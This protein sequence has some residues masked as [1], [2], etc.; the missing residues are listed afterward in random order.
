M[1]ISNVP[2]HNTNPLDHLKLS[3]K[4]LIVDT[5]KAISDLLPKSGGK[6][7]WVDSAH[8]WIVAFSLAVTERDENK[9]VSFPSLYRELMNIQADYDAWVAFYNHMKQ[10]RFQSVRRTAEAISESQKLGKEGFLAPMN[11]IS[12]VFSWM[13]EP[14]IANSLHGGPSLGEINNPDRNVKWKIIIPAQYI[15]ICK[16]LVRS[17]IGRPMQDKMK[18]GGPQKV[19]VNIDEC[20]VLGLFPSILEGYVY[21]RGQNLAMLCGFQDLGQLYAAFGRDKASA[22]LSSAQIQVYARTGSASTAKHASDMAGVTTLQFHDEHKQADASH[23]KN[24]A[25]NAIM[26]GADMMQV[27][28]EL[29]HH[30]ASEQRPSQQQRMLVTPDEF[31]F[32]KGLMK[33]KDMIAFALGA[34]GM[35]RYSV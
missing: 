28:A 3:S 9:G 14:A 33:N 30:S 6:E 26:Q 11:T 4:T 5:Q 16:P 1:G 17:L 2:Q 21:G 8:D 10:S 23:R 20:G 27:A 24:M 7:W 34:G 13:Q 35:G 18:R 25:M 31:R 32:N 15:E 22:L 12:S 29:N 19:A